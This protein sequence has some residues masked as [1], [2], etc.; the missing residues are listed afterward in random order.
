MKVLVKHQ[1]PITWDPFL[2]A[3]DDPAKELTRAALETFLWKPR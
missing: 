2:V 3:A 1:K